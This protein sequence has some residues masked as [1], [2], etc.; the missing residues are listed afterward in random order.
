MTCKY[1]GH[2]ELDMVG[3]TQTLFKEGLGTPETLS[4]L[5]IRL[6]VHADGDC[7]WWR[8]RQE[9]LSGCPQLGQTNFC[10]SK[11]WINSGTNGLGVWREQYT[12]VILRLQYELLKHLSANSKL[13]K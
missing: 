2:T 5:G 8:G 11:G 10:T 9:K 12:W 1:S 3:C 7:A 13:I 6:Q 4:V